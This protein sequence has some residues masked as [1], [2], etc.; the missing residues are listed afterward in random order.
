MSAAE[1][2]HCIWYGECFTDPFMHRKNCRY[3]GPAK[4]LDF[5]GQELLAKNCPHLVKDSGTG[6]KTCCDTE[7]LKTMDKNIKLA[8]NFISRCPSCLDNLVKHFCEFTCSTEQS[9]FINVTETK[10]E[11]GNIVYLWSYMHGKS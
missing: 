4:P 8:A 7:Q 11:K 6:I 3:D 5:E 2:G 9:K 10:K 1:E